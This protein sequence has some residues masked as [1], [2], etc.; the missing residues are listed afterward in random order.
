MQP[1]GPD[2]L[3]A[4]LAQALA[5]L[6]EID[7]DDLAANGPT[8]GGFSVQPWRTADHPEPPVVP[9]AAVTLPAAEDL[10]ATFEPQEAVVTSLPPPTPA[11]SEPQ[12][13]LDTS[14]VPPNSDSSNN[15]SPAATT[16]PSDSNESE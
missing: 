15:P 8:I 12:D 16:P 14:P 10:P 13:A 1:P 9:L 2:N 3:R 7:L 4:R 5:D 11:T 6:E